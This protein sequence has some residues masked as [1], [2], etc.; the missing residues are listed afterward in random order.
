MKM[1]YFGC[2]T[3]ELNKNASIFHVQAFL[4]SVDEDLVE[5]LARRL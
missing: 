5:I 4:W 2:K 3:I 1:S